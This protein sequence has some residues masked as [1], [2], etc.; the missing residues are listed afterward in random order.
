MPDAMVRLATR[1][2]EARLALSL[3]A[4]REEVRQAIMP[5]ARR[6]GLAELREAL[7]KVVAIQRHEVMI[8]YLMLADVNDS[9]EDAGALIAYLGDLSVHINLIPY[10]PIE[11]APH[12]RGSDP[13]RREAFSATLKQAGFPVTTRYSLGSDIAA[14]CGQLVRGRQDRSRAAEPSSL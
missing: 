3:H 7:E 2:P 9:P 10:N 8:E 4:A 6:H 5:I 11:G 14:A 12:L 1:Y 13:D